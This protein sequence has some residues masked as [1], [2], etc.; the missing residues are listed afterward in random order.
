MPWIFAKSCENQ[1]G[2]IRIGK[3]ENPGICGDRI[4]SAL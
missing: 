3:S 1:E 4:L 2:G